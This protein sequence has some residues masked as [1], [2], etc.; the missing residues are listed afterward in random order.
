MFRCD[1]DNYKFHAP[2]SIAEGVTLK[3]HYKINGRILV[4]PI[5]GEG[6]CELNLGQCPP[7]EA[8]REAG[9][10]LRFLAGCRRRWLSL[11]HD[12]LFADNITAGV[13]LVGK[14]LSKNNN[15]YMEVADFK[16]TFETT[17]L[18]V[19]LENLFNGNKQLSK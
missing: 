4:L 12:A 15:K 19:K 14:E 10:Y 9:V 3:G 8:R 1:I 17:R 13:D 5:T 11:T 16:F 2:L 7:G 18:K 6:A